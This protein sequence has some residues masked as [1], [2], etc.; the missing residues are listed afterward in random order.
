MA[1]LALAPS[2]LIESYRQW[3]QLACATVFK[4]RSHTSEVDLHQS[5]EQVAE[6][7]RSTAIGHVNHVDAG[8]HL[9][10]ACDLKGL[11]CQTGLNAPIDAKRVF[12]ELSNFQ[13]TPTTPARRAARLGAG[14]LD[15]SARWRRRWSQPCRMSAI[16]RRDHGSMPE[17]EHRIARAPRRYC[18]PRPCMVWTRVTTGGFQRPVS[19]SDFGA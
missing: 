17:R 12:R 16:V 11:H 6:R 15:L 19:T 14:G 3:A 7:G 1:G 8:H 2:R 5:T 10:H 13:S 18:A 4:R 9:R